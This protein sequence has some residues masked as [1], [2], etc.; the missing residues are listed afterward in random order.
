MKILILTTYR[1]RH[2]D[3][4]PNRC[5]DKFQLFTYLI[6]KQLSLYDDV[7]IV[8]GE[9]EYAVSYPEADHAILVDDMGFFK[10]V[11]SFIRKLKSVVSGVICSIGNFPS[12]HGGEDVLFHF[13][14][15][16]QKRYNIEKINWICDETMLY[17]KKVT[18]KIN[19]LVG[20]PATRYYQ[21]KKDMSIQI[22]QKVHKFVNNNTF[23]FD[24]YRED[25]QEINAIKIYDMYNRTHIY[26]VT[27]PVS[28]VHF[29]YELS[30]TNAV[31]VSPRT[32]VDTKTVKFLE[33]I[34]YDEVLPWHLIFERMNVINIREKL[35]SHGLTWRSAVKHMISY[36]VNI[37]KPT[38][39]PKSIPKFASLKEKLEYDARQK[40]SPAPKRELKLVPKIQKPNPLRSKTVLLQS[41]LKSKNLVILRQPKTSH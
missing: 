14:G 29:L 25:K 34:E 2:T 41:E 16:P 19:I 11:P 39:E 36:I 40:P 37:P 26:F 30:M 35:L 32:Y 23:P 13:G 15:K 10:R 18:D 12:H 9:T 31:I 33:I 27:C 28:N 1:V 4:D 8:Y 24:V 6:H 7:E 38:S 22:L 3:L 21:K 17:P 20:G 5:V